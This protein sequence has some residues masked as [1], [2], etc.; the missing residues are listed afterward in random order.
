MDIILNT[1]TNNHHCTFG[2]FSGVEANV[3]K[4]E[5]LLLNGHVL[6]E[7]HTLD[8]H[9]DAPKNHIKLAM[10]IPSL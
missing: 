2:K 9:I 3:F 8:H 1:K 6:S 4:P 10:S 5:T 7:G